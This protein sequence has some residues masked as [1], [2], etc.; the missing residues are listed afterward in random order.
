MRGVVELYYTPEELAILLRLHVK[1]VLRQIRE[2]EFGAEVVN[3]GS[4]ARPD[5]RVPSGGVNGYLAA[6]RVFF[7]GDGGEL[8][9]AARSVGE[10]RRKA[11]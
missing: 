10:L 3:L 9:V 11:A 7:E 6:R 5:Y 1:T 2:R 8:G 4:E